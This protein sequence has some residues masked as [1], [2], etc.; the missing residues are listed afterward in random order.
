LTPAI[1]KGLLSCKVYIPI[2]GKNWLNILTDK[3][4]DSIDYVRQEILLALD[5]AMDPDVHFIIIPVLVDTTLEPPE[6]PAIVA[7]LGAYI[8]KSGIWSSESDILQTAQQLTENIHKVWFDEPNIQMII[9]DPNAFMVANPQY[10]HKCPR[11]KVNALKLTRDPRDKTNYSIMVNH[12]VDKIIPWSFTEDKIYIPMIGGKHRIDVYSNDDESIT[13]YI[14]LDLND[15][16]SV[17]IK[18][19]QIKSWNRLKAIELNIPNEWGAYQN[20]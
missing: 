4:D 1:E 3:L 2:I 6:L 9:P 14:L 17:Q 20:N 10:R 12:S 13:N 18:V 7:E 19:T 11:V 16:F 5:Q 8:E 15:N